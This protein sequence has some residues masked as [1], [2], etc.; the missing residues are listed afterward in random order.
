MPI[1][2]TVGDKIAADATLHRGRAVSRRHIGEA[3]VVVEPDFRDKGLGKQLIQEIID[4][5]AD[6]E[7]Q[8]LVFDLVAHREE[9]AF[10]AARSRGF[11]DVTVQKT[12]GTD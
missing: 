7:L 2:A 9:P 5:A 3:R 8:K 11:R 4:I 1:I 12:G 6:L 10:V